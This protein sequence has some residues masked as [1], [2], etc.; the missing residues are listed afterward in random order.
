MIAL[1][2]PNH[3]DALD[4]YYRG[5]LKA[6]T[7][8]RRQSPFIIEHSIHPVDGATVE[9]GHT[10]SKPKCD[11]GNHTSSKTELTLRSRIGLYTPEH[12]QYIRKKERER[13]NGKRTYENH[14]M[15]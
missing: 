10:V 14:L 3:F 5:G 11:H 9:V 8:S 4:R 6:T 1:Y 12:I 2:S 7:S 13:N 15:F